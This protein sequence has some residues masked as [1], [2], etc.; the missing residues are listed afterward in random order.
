MVKPYLVLFKEQN[1][2]FL[3][4]GKRFQG[5][6]VSGFARATQKL[7]ANKSR[8]NITAQATITIEFFF[9][10]FYNEK[11]IVAWEMSPQTGDAIPIPSYWLIK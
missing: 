2:P 4:Q 8:T 6:L 5:S 11:G 9:A 1:V 3:E 10:F 7:F